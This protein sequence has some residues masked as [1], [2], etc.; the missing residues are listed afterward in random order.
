M[1]RP[2]IQL[3]GNRYGV[4]YNG[5]VLRMFK[6]RDEAIRFIREEWSA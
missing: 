3:V 1:S 4:I 6:T 2:V 5:V